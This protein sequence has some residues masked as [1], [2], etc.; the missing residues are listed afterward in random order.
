LW[1]VATGGEIAIARGQG[2]SIQA[3]SFSPDGRRFATGGNDGT[4]R[5]WDGH[6]GAQL[7]VCR[8]HSGSVHA[9]AFNPDGRRLVSAGL[10]EDDRCRLWN[11]ATGALIAVLPAQAT[12]HGLTFTPDGGRIVCCRNESI[13]V[14]DASF[15]ENVTVSFENK[16]MERSVPGAIVFC[17][18]VSPDGR[19]LVTGWDY[20][21]NAVRLWDLQSGELLAVMTGH[22][23]RVSSVTFSPNGRRIASASQDQT[24]RVWDAANGKAVAVLRGHT[25]HVIQ[26]VISPD[27]RYVVSASYDGT[28]RV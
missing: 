22:A 5:L 24:V 28:L 13:I 14:V 3:V 8:G 1:D 4:V 20:P 27:G 16:V 10:P 21:D 17:C 12:T 6:T 2:A 18:A 23:N 15:N 9:L 19:R 25:S 11:A 26:V 7:G